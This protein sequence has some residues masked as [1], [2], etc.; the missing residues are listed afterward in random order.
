MPKDIQSIENLI[1]SSNGDAGDDDARTEFTK[2]AKEIKIKEIERS[3]KRIADDSGIPHIN[4][5]SFSI[6]PEALSLIEEEEAR[7][8][9]AVCFYFDGKNIRIG[10]IDPSN[11]EVSAL[12]EELKKKYYSKGKLYL[13]S[14]HSFSH[15]LELYK[16]IPK[17]RKIIR[18][19]NIDEE[20]LNKYSEKFSSFRDVQEQINE[21]P[22]VTDIV[23]V[24]MSAAVKTGSSD[25]HIEVEEKG[26]KVRFRIDGVLHNVASIKKELWDKVVLRYK[27]L[28]KVKIN[29]S[30]KPQDGRM[31]I[32]M[33]NDRIDIRASFLPTAYGESIVMRLLRASSVGLEFEELGIRSKAFKQLKK[34]VE[35]PNGMIITTGPTGSGKTT[36]LYAIL[37]RLNKPETKIITIED[38]IEYQLKG[39]NQSQISDKYT[40]A[41]GLRSIV[42][43][44][45][46]ILMVGE[47]RDLETAEIAIQ[48]ALTGHLVLSTIH[49]NNAAG[50]V[51]RFLSMGAKPF[52]LA[53]ALNAIIG[54]RL[55]RRIC[56]K[57]KHEVKIEDEKLEHIKEIL[58]KL[59]E[60]DKKNINF[61][62]SKF[63]E[64]KGCEFCQGIGYKGRIGIY[65]I[66][67]IN[68]EVEK[69]I[70]SGKVSEY[71]MSETAVKD[72]MINMVQDG[73]LKALEGVTSVKEVF[74][75]SQMKK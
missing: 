24:I 15:A 9:S 11:T 43:Q 70:L 32:F 57:C 38:P 60:E 8:L 69:I 74:R 16:S 4:L 14:K 41:H 58:E 65:E 2:K 46:D 73:L 36:T 49:T 26:I 71:D 63:Y 39:V 50:T 64:G 19:I 40:F 21:T 47:I 25:V 53:P 29:I 27:V 56:E 30:N 7:R 44:D 23:T 67:T 34:E 28:T 72:G 3:T 59:P 13:I 31:S 17:P 45:P 18:G 5:A 42:R 54:Q 35:R 1:S 6:S 48:A 10:A 62:D 37:K 22:K 75:V 33:K 68:K 66:M 55:V 61:N 12:L 20:D 51:P 52:L